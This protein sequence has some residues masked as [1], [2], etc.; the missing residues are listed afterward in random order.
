MNSQ[1]QRAYRRLSLRVL[2][3]SP[4]A[5]F[6]FSRGRRRLSGT[7]LC[8]RPT[9][10]PQDQREVVADSQFAD[11]DAVERGVDMLSPLRVPAR[12]RQ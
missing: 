12:A 4:R 5:L 2:L 6:K 1:S 11:V 10:R 9:D 3:K 7:G 8:Q